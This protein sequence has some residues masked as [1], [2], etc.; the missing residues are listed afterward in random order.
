M[1]LYRLFLQSYL[2]QA[3]FL[4][5][6]YFVWGK[7]VETQYRKLRN[8]VAFLPLF[9]F[10]HFLRSFP[11]IMPNTFFN[12]FDIYFHIKRRKIS[13]FFRL[14]FL[15]YRDSSTYLQYFIESMAYKSSTEI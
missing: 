9:P 1:C 5:M 14:S 8:F 7:G 12:L 4:I 10:F 2:P 15:T 13:F 6:F 3:M 11:H